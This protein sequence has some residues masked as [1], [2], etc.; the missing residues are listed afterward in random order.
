[1]TFL[2]QAQVYST[3]GILCDHDI[4]KFVFNKR[5]MKESQA[6]INEFDGWQRGDI[7]RSVLS[8][9]VVRQAS[10]DAQLVKDVLS[11][12]QSDAMM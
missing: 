12:T 7:D 3:C 11:E 5:K 6:L 9:M 10:D 4:T 2:V 8:K 1:M